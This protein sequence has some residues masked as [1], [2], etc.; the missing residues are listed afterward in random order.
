MERRKT[1]YVSASGNVNQINALINAIVAVRWKLVTVKRVAVFRTASKTLM[2]MSWPGFQVEESSSSLVR[3][4]VA[5][6]SFLSD[7]G[8][9]KRFRLLWPSMQLALLV[10]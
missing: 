1:I 9:K 6:E 8:V 5:Y 7:E 2:R 3:T 10:T 4:E